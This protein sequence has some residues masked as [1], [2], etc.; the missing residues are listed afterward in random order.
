MMMLWEHRRRGAKG[1]YVHYVI[2]N[3]AESQVE[4]LD[5]IPFGQGDSLLQSLA[6]EHVIPLTYQ[7]A[8]HVFEEMRLQLAKARVELTDEVQNHWATVDR[9][10]AMTDTHW[11]S[12]ILRLMGRTLDAKETVHAYFQGWAIDDW[13]L[14]YHLM[15][16]QMR[17]KHRNH[18][19]YA[20]QMSKKHGGESL[21]RGIVVEEKKSKN[22]KEQQDPKKR[23]FIAQVLVGKDNQLLQQRMHFYV[24]LQDEQWVIQRTRRESAKEI[25]PGSEP[26]F[27]GLWYWRSFAVPNAEHVLDLLRQKEGC[28]V[29]END[30]GLAIVYVSHMNDAIELGVDVSRDA[31]GQIWIGRREIVLGAVS[32]DRLASLLQELRRE[33]I[34]GKQSGKGPFQLPEAANY[35]YREGHFDS[36]EEFTK[37]WEEEYRRAGELEGTMITFE[38]SQLGTLLTQF[39]E[40]R[41]ADQWKQSWKRFSRLSGEE[42]KSME[43]H[44]QGALFWEWFVFDQTIDNQRTLDFF[45][46]EVGFH[47]PKGMIEKLEQWQESVP[48]FYVITSVEEK[49][50]WAEDMF[51]KKSYYI[52]DNDCKIGEAPYEE[53]YIIFSRLIPREKKWHYGGV[54]HFFPRWY[55][56]SIEKFM[57]SIGLWNSSRFREEQWQPRSWSILMFLV[58]LCKKPIIPKLFTME[59]HLAGMSRAV[60]QVK[61]YSAVKTTVEKL[62]EFIFVARERQKGQGEYLR[63]DWIESGLTSQMMRALLEDPASKDLEGLCLNDIFQPDDE[64]KEVRQVGTFMLHKQ[65]AVIDTIS[66]ERLDILKHVLTKYCGFYLVH[67]EDFFEE[68]EVLAQSSAQ[69][70]Q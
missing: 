18:L 12:L 22:S 66:M 61:D 65:Y 38:A 52:E 48:G 69:E 59:G 21:L 13:S 5:G 50:F 39:I 60:Y 46:D 55:R 58:E 23:H 15:P 53:G 10:E 44:S 19:T 3:P 33:K 7:E 43:E 27:Q 51:R 54:A 68:A 49:A 20:R 2:A 11:H 42:N 32:E 56:Q 31:R 29:D 30:E 41:F 34:L 8:Y 36:F 14:V 70:K 26:F 45:I 28:H 37:A 35:L 6:E 24:E 9:P 64:G 16:A 57:E 17:T 40:W 47:L 25:P 1:I 67:D 62:S 4:W 63:Y